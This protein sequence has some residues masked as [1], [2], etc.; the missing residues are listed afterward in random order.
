MELAAVFGNLA[1]DIRRDQKRWFRQGVASGF[2]DRRSCKSV[3]RSYLSTKSVLAAFGFELD[4]R[5][6]RMLSGGHSMARAGGNLSGPPQCKQ[7][8]VQYSLLLGSHRL[9]PKRDFGNTFTIFHCTRI[10]DILK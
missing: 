10:V 8:A 3:D 2:D 9:V 1:R 5:V 7:G 4:N 6:C